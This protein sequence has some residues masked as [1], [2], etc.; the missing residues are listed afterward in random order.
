MQVTVDF[1][2]GES[3]NVVFN[4]GQPD[5]FTRSPGNIYAIW[6]EEPASGFLQ[7][8]FTCQKLI[9]DLAVNTTI[10][11]TALPYWNEH[12]YNS[13][14]DTITGATRAK[15]DFTVSAQMNSL[16]TRTFSVWFEIDRSWEENDWFSDQPSLIF[17]ADVDLDD[18]VDTYTM[19]FYGWSSNNDNGNLKSDFLIST[20][21]F[22]ELCSEL[23]YVNYNAVDPD[24]N[25]VYEFGVPDPA[26][27]TPN[28]GSHYSDNHAIVRSQG[29]SR[30]IWLLFCL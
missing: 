26:S 21:D 30:C 5:E 9:D 1:Y 16:E 11:G 23:R 10:S 7:H 3:I 28:G 19:D 8:I 4:E 15:S 29:Y 6:M 13:A 2:Y 20:V 22:G 12:I 18:G 27:A 14:A 24:S 17:K 25:G